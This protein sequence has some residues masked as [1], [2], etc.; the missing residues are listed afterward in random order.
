MDLLERAQEL[1]RSGRDIIH[2]EIGAPDFDTPQPAKDAA[3][4]ALQ[5]GK[6]GYT[7][8]L[9]L[10][11]LREAIAAHYRSKY[12]VEV[13]AGRVVVTSGTSPA[14]LLILSALLEPEDEVL[15]ADPGYAPYLL[16]RLPALT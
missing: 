1:E 16:S 13:D 6:T 9:G 5:E 10:L 7:H 8:S 11:E 4:R 12:R 3:I 2:L 14:L 15:L